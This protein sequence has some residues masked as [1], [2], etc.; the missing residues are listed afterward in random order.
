MKNLL[1]KLIMFFY[2]LALK[3]IRKYMLTYRQAIL[4]K[5]YIK[6]L[7]LFPDK[8][9]A[10]NRKI[11]LV[12]N[13]KLCNLTFEDPCPDYKNEVNELYD[14]L[15][16][17]SWVQSAVSDYFLIE[18][19]FY[20]FSNKKD[21]ERQEAKEAIEKAKDWKNDVSNLS[22]ETY[23]T[24]VSFIKKELKLLKNE[25]KFLTNKKLEDEKLKSFPPIKITS[26]H[27]TFLFSLF[28]SLFIL[29]GFVY[30]YYLLKHFNISVSNFFNIS[31]YLASSVDVITASLIATFIAIISFLLG[32]NRGVEQ[33]FYDEEF[34]TKS[35]TK[36]DIL[37]AILVST[38]TINLVLHSYFT[39][40]VH[41]TTLSILIFFISINTIP[42]LPI[43]KYIEN[44]LTILVVIFSLITFSL[45]MYYSIDK[46]IKKI[47]ANNLKSDYELIFDNKFKGNKNSKFLLANSTYVFL[48]DP[49]IEKIIIIPK[50]EVRMFKAK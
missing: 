36:K 29:S 46:K 17:D 35:T 34:E 16:N 14:V 13:F 11:A 19:Y 28:S 2:T 44:K 43:W 42:M 47:E 33:H 41:S 7:S 21:I 48:W 23:K 5:A 3:N 8:K 25:I 45:H 49:Q 4:L 1:F 38:L 32:L 12:A 15:K 10:D 20:S 26:A 27:I 31:D 18:A 40:E 22:H 24:K 6:A 37:P 50:G 9:L 39:G 30:N